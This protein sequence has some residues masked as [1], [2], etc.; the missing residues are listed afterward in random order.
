M[1]LKMKLIVLPLLVMQLASCRL[2][3]CCFGKKD[4]LNNS[5]LY[6][7]PQIHLIEGHPYV[8]KEGVLIG[9]GQRFHSDY[10]YRRMIIEQ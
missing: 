9:R 1:K 7:P 2:V 4:T 6:D 3:D 8:F 5:A 10:D